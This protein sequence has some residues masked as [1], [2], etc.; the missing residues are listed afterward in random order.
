MLSTKW[1]VSQWHQFL[2][3]PLADGPFSTQGDMVLVVS[4]LSLLVQVLA[5]PSSARVRW[6]RQAQPTLLQENFVDGLLATTLM[7]LA[8]REAEK[9][10]RLVT[11]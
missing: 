11:A 4:K 10:K 5:S 9:L 8:Y 2:P 6:L 1:P 7:R 3:V